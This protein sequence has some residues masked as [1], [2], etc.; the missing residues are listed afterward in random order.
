MSAVLKRPSEHE[1]RRKEIFKDSRPFVRKYLETDLGFLWAAY[2]NGSFPIPQGL[3][4]EDFL[5]AMV[6][7]FGAFNLL[8]II[9]DDSSQFK[10]GRGQVGLVGIKTDG[11]TF[12][13]VIYF[14]KWAGETSRKRSLIAL[15]HM[16]RFQKDVGVFLV[17]A[18]ESEKSMFDP[19]K[20]YGVLYYRGVVPYGS[21]SGNLYLYSINGRKGV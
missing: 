11:W 13:P 14:F 4:Q 9:E 12:E 6:V 20:D 3:T 16:M 17:K 21:P 18:T 10:S 19:L 8:W 7:Q 2:K 5:P 15:C 1:K